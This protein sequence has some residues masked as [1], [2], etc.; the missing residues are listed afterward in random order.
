MIC[1]YIFFQNPDKF[2]E[3]FDE[4]LYLSYRLFL[5]VNNLSFSGD[6]AF[7]NAGDFCLKGV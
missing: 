1:R 3:Y 2:S 5:I 6:K 4:L 7:S